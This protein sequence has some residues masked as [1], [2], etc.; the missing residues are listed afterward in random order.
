MAIRAPMRISRLDG[1]SESTINSKRINKGPLALI[2]TS[3]F[4]ILISLQIAE[5][6]KLDFPLKKRLRLFPFFQSL[7]LVYLL[8]VQQNSSICLLYPEQ[9]QKLF[10]NLYWTECF[11]MQCCKK[12]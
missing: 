2:Y 3:K 6:H 11:L 1:F 5:I 8:Y 12:H 7:H 4:K 9:L 10:L